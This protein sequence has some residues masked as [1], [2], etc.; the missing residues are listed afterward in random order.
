MCG[1]AL[2]RFP[3]GGMLDVVVR[4]AADA[5]C[6]DCRR[7]RDYHSDYGLE[8]YF[9]S[10]SLLTRQ[11]KCHILSLNQVGGETETLNMEVEFAELARALVVELAELRRIDGADVANFAPV[12][13]AFLLG[14][15]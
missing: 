3:T 13:T 10:P 1:V 14:E 6:K 8:R 4:N 2:M 9:T 11:K 5:R 12:V 15:R 7:L